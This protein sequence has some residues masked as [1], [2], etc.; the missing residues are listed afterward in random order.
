MVLCY[1]LFKLKIA[2][3]QHLFTVPKFVVGRC[4]HVDFIDNIVEHIN[5][6]YTPHVSDILHF[7]WKFINK[8]ITLSSKQITY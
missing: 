4:V 6:N 8:Y 3:F 7:N 5:Y 1:I 2:Y